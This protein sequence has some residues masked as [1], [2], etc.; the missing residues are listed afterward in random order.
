MKTNNGF[1]GTAEKRIIT[2]TL[3][4]FLLGLSGAHA[5]SG[6][7]ED[8]LVVEGRV[9]FADTLLWEITE[10]E[11][12]IW[13]GRSMSNKPAGG[14]VRYD[15]GYIRIYNLPPGQYTINIRVDLNPGNKES[16][17]GDLNAYSDFKVIEGEVAERNIPLSEVMHLVEPVDNSATLLEF[18]KSCYMK[19]EHQRRLLFEWKPVARTQKYYYKVTRGTCSPFTRG[20]VVESGD[21]NETHVTVDLLPTDSNEYYAFSVLARRNG[22]SI[23]HLVLHGRNGHGWDYRFKVR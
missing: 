8:V 13:I 2:N 21:T 9:T 18:E 1:F 23:G 16:Y 12:R 3:F 14:E 10:I 6:N 11:P 4:V 17:P 19:R 5:D 20:R 22:D 7:V 15:K